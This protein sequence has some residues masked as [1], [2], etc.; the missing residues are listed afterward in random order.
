MR[1]AD[2]VVVNSVH[3]REFAVR[4]EGA[5][6]DRIFVIPNGVCVDDYSTAICRMS[7]RRNLGLSKG[8]KLVGSVGRLTRQKGFD[9][10]LKAVSLLNGLDLDLVISGVGEEEATLRSM[11]DKLGVQKR[12]HFMGYCR[13]IPSFLRSLDLYVHPARFEGMPNAVLEAMAAGC[14]IV[15]TAVDGTLELIEDGKHG[16]LVPPEDPAALASALEEVLTHPDEARRRGT[17]ARGRVAEHF[18]IEKM[19]RSWESILSG[20]QLQS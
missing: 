1:S 11:S 6:P 12:I 16:W 9:V 7:L 5:S 14:A 19:I 8:N 3:V 20:E 13:D 2:A 10:L 4:E 17:A 18:T 15:A